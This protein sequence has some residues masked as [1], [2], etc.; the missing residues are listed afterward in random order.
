M[1]GATTLRILIL[2]KKCEDVILTNRRKKMPL[3]VHYTKHI[4]WD[5]DT[6]TFA[7]PKIKQE[8]DEIGHFL[9]TIGVSK[10]SEKTIDEIVIRKLILDKF[11]P[12]TAKA[13][14]KTPKEWREIFSKHM[15][16]DIQGRW[17]CD[18]TR[19]KFT[20]RHAKGMMFDIVHKVLREE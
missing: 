12:V 11:Y 18:E 7:D 1:Q 17:A 3:E 4:A 5:A 13:E 10:I 20:S 6:K 16:L 15:G 2:I 14:N 8:A 9:M 19:W